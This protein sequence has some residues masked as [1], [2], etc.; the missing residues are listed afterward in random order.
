MGHHVGDV[1]PPSCTLFL[2]PPPLQ[3]G[4]GGSGAPFPWGT[5]FVHAP[6]LQTGSPMNE[7]W[8]LHMSP[9][10]HVSPPFPPSLLLPPS[11]LTV[12]LH[13]NQGDTSGR[14]MHSQGAWSGRCAQTES[15]ACPPFAPP[16]TPPAV[17]K[18]GGPWRGEVPTVSLPT[19]AP[20]LGVPPT[21]AR[22]PYCPPLVHGQERHTQT[23]QGWAQHMP[24]PS[25]H[26][27][28]VVR[29]AR[30]SGGHPEKGGMCGNGKGQHP[31]HP[32]TMPHL[33]ASANPCTATHEPGA[34]HLNL[35]ALPPPS[36]SAHCNACKPAGGTASAPPYACKPGCRRHSGPFPMPSPMCSR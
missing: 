28:R 26:Q 1:M 29:G 17:Y 23:G 32:C 15:D 27:G 25:M 4:C 3:M 12:C 10:L 21:A 13:A 19:H 9:L 14:S 11:T 8:G 16:A 7:G 18:P 2:A 35:E 6:S 20:L 30:S 33:Q 36:C 31:L 24:S 34:W 22:S 5:R